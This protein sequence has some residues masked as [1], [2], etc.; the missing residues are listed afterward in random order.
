MM[1]GYSI[2]A[3]NDVTINVISES[4][5][6]VDVEME[7][8]FTNEDLAGQ[9]IFD[10]FGMTSP[11]I[12]SSTQKLLTNVFQQTELTPATTDEYLMAVIRM[13]NKLRE[14][15]VQYGISSEEFWEH[16]NLHI[17]EDTYETNDW[18]NLIYM[19]K[20]YET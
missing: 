7:K 4:Y 5:V 8:V 11:G 19:K 20:R 1:L 2:S 15:E 17:S 3:I 18:A 12:W 9:H 14:Y 13:Q 16:W 10:V 6:G